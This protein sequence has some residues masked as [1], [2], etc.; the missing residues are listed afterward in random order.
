MPLPDSKNIVVD[1]RAASATDFD[2]FIGTWRIHHRRLKERLVGCSQWELFEG[3]SKAQKLLGGLANVD[4]NLLHLPDGDYRALTLR[5][6]D[7]ATGQW[8][9][10]WLDGRHPGRL[11]APMVGSFTGGVGHFYADD[12]YNGQAIRVRFLWTKRSE[13]GQPR[14]EQ[15]FSIDGGATWEVNWV[16]DFTPVT[17]GASE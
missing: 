4:D 1:A 17:A 5:S 12:T 8:S 16:M 9:I 3:R 14:W 11:D 13:L 15:A 7:V 10:W 2:F 6:F